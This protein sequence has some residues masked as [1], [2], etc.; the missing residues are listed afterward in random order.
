MKNKLTMKN[1]LVD[2]IGLTEIH[3][4]KLSALTHKQL[5][6]FDLPGVKTIPFE[7]AEN[8]GRDGSALW[9]SDVLGNIATYENPY[10]KLNRE[11]YV[12]M[13]DKEKKEGISYVKYK[14]K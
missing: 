10:K 12:T 14:R 6:L 13:A 3:A 11:C 9:V 2:Y 1:F 4:T 7:V 8:L 5:K